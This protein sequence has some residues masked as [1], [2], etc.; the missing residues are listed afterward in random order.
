MSRQNF[1]I[2]Y[3][4]IIQVHD[5]T[6]VT[7]RSKQ[8]TDLTHI[9]ISFPWGQIDRNV[10]LNSVNSFDSLDFACLELLFSLYF[11]Y[12]VGILVNKC[13]EIKEIN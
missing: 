3:F 2:D 13:A 1:L 10:T 11:H 7:N 12:M 5:T 8:L 4:K 6:G 9:V